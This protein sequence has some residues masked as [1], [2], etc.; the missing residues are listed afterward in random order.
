MHCCRLKLE[1]HKQSLAVLEPENKKLK[2]ECHHLQKVRGT[3]H[4]YMY[5]HMY[6]TSSTC[7][8]DWC[9]TLMSWFYS[10][11]LY[12]HNIY[13]RGLKCAKKQ[14]IHVYSHSPQ[15]SCSIVMVLHKYTVYTHCIYSLYAGAVGA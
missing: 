15:L 9:T 11:S 4:M 8:H 5:I 7:T 6:T 13:T 2:Q 3:W 12:I 10:H 14:H 1:S